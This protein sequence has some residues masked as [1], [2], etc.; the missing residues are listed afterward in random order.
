MSISSRILIVD[1]QD[2]NLDMLARRLS[3]NGYAVETATSGSIALSKI[4]DTQIDLVLLDQMMPLM[5]GTAVLA[6]L[7]KTLSP[8]QMPV[9]MVTAISD[10]LA[11]ADA[12]DRGANDYVTKPV[13]FPVVLARIRAQLARRQTH[14]ELQRSAD[15]HDID[16]SVAAD[17]KWDWEVSGHHLY[18]SCQAKSL[19]GLPAEQATHQFK[20]WLARLHPGDRQR[21]EDA[22]TI[23]VPVTDEERITARKYSKADI[24]SDFRVQKASGGYQWLAIQ[25]M[26]L[27]S[28]DGSVLRRVGSV[29]HASERLTVDV[30]TGLPNRSA[31]AQEIES[32]YSGSSNISSSGFLLYTFTLDRYKLLHSSV[33]GD[34]GESLVCQVA[35]RT[36]SILTNHRNSGRTGGCEPFLAKLGDDNFAILADPLCL[37]LDAGALAEV[38]V[39]SMRQ[40]FVVGERSI[41]CSISLGFVL[42]TEG[43]PDFESIIGDAQIARHTAEARG[44]NQWTQFTP[45]M[46][47]LREQKLQMDIDLRLALERSEFEVFYQSR[48]DLQT[49][50]T[51]GFEA[52]VRWNHPTRGLVSPADFIPSLEASGL[53]RE[54]GIWVLRQAC[55]Q[56]QVWRRTYV[57]DDNFEVAVNL[58]AQQCRDPRLVEQVAQVLV[59]TGLPPSHLKLEL[60]ESIF[61]EDIGESREVLTALTRLGVGLKLDDFGTGYSC[62]KYLQDLPFESLKLDRSFTVDLDRNRPDAEEIVRTIVQMA[63]NLQLQ[64]VAE[65]IE[66]PDHARLL[67]EMGCQYGQG[68]LFSRPINA[69]AA[70]ELLRRDT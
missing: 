42:H 16:A 54:L 6:E 31:L 18:L 44:K 52:L 26:T 65:G 63:S 56:A 37:S 39:A 45:S 36:K 67:K 48:V 9:I 34:G 57:V 13:D 1:D 21:L 19:I 20:D 68:Y 70:G 11:I 35:A 59:E 66:S 30:L 29:S 64:V 51:C 33:G 49:G 38:L 8:Q 69:D 4:K 47:K 7:R 46:R 28:S 12:L 41:L 22:L 40:P 2:A 58:S 5:N 3:R 60:T 24:Q 17:E 27:Y 53:V 25:G 32:R 23:G 55:E 14:L 50:K 43:Q 15:H 62:F 10:G 61:L